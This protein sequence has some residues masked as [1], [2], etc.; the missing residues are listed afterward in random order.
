M[1][2]P[3]LWLWPKAFKAPCMSTGVSAVQGDPPFY[4]SAVELF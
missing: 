2:Q 3:V 4:F 1:C